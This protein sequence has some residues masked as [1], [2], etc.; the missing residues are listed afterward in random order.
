[1]ENNKSYIFSSIFGS[2]L[3]HKNPTRFSRWSFRTMDEDISIPDKIK[4]ALVAAETYCCGVQR[5]FRIINTKYKEGI[6]IK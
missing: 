2:Y 1:M 4:K 3:V 6:V 5:P